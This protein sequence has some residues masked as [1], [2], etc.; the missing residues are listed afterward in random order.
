MKLV[1]PLFWKKIFLFHKKPFRST[2]RIC[3]VM[4]VY[5][6]SMQFCQLFLISLIADS[7]IFLFCKISWICSCSIFGTKK[8]SYFF[9]IEAVSSKNTISFF[10]LREFFWL[11]YGISGILNSFYMKF[12]PEKRSKNVMVTV[13]YSCFFGIK[14]IEIKLLAKWEAL[15]SFCGVVWFLKTGFKK[16]Q[17]CWGSTPTFRWSFASVRGG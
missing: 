16:T 13:C 15:T 9:L 7:V 1:I 8:A 6:H 4:Q 10:I 11:S 17:L 3:Q 2:S 12:S 5:S 14:E